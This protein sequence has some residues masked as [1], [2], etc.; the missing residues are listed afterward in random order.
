M[1]LG[2]D[3]DN[4]KPAVPYRTRGLFPWHCLKFVAVDFNHLHRLV[5]Y[6]VYYVGFIRIH[7]SLASAYRLY[8]RPPHRLTS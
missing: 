5:Q 8:M 1:Y 2:R 7:I 6:V 4:V 3:T